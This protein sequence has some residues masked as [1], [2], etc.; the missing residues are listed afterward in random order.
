MMKVVAAGFGEEAYSVYWGFSCH[1]F[2]FIVPN[3][4]VYL[5]LFLD[6]LIIV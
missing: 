6:I 5:I 4:E 2:D 1:L 3:N